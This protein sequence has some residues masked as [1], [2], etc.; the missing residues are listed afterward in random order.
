[1]ALTGV[2]N[3]D[4]LW[5]CVLIDKTVAGV[6]VWWIHHVSLS[7]GPLDYEHCSFLDA[8]MMA[9]C[10]TWAQPWG[11]SCHNDYHD[12]SSFDGLVWW[13]LWLG[14]WHHGF[15]IGR[16]SHLMTA[17]AGV[18]SKWCCDEGFGTQWLISQDFE[19]CCYS[20]PINKE[21]MTF[22]PV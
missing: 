1:M 7:C 11:K 4:P 12:N 13:Q 21:F 14:S 19:P 3:M 22:C 17:V 10:A 5:G 8:M 18:L 15:T 20:A 16:L 9:F 2:Q 6:L